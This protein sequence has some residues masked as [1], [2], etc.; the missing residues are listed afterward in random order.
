MVVDLHHAPS[1]WGYHSY[2]SVLGTH[3]I[4]D[5]DVVANDK[6]VYPCLAVTSVGRRRHLFLDLPHEFLLCA[7]FVI[8]KALILNL[9]FSSP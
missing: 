6:S 5:S 2:D 4:N 1:W 8:H 7:I 9:G 3:M